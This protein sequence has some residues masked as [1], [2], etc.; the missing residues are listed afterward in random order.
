MPHFRLPRRILS[1][2]RYKHMDAERDLEN[3]VELSHFESQ[4]SLPLT[5]PVQ[6]NVLCNR[7]ATAAQASSRKG[8]SVVF[9]SHL[10][11]DFILKTNR[12]ALEKLLKHLL[13]NATH[14]TRKGTITLSCNESGENIRFTVTDTSS[15]LGDTHTV[16]VFGRLI[17]P[18]FKTQTVCMNFNICHSIARLL[19]GRVWIDKDYTDGI[20]FCF[21]VPKDVTIQS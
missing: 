21:E 2:L 20:R 3:I 14:F 11:D 10:P 18:T 19:H 6:P 8:V 13:D 17:D 1:L 12:D 9:M 16:N 7:L 5:T 4:T 15:G